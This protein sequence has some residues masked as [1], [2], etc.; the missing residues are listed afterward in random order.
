MVLRGAFIPQIERSAP[1]TR[2]SQRDHDG[3]RAFFHKS[4]THAPSI[5]G[6]LD[7]KIEKAIYT[8]SSHLYTTGST[9]KEESA[10]TVENTFLDG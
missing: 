4:F 10:S 8:I 1:N 9:P 7:D 3:D 5:G 2:S 6:L